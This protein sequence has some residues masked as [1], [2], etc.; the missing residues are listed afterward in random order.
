MRLLILLGEACRTNSFIENACIMCILS[1]GVGRFRILG[2]MG[3]V[4]SGGGLLAV[5]KPT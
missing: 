3:G 1:I 4:G 2:K 5:W